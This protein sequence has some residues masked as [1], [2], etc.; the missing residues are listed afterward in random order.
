MTL[1]CSSDVCND[2]C[3]WLRLQENCGFSAVAVH[4]GRRFPVA[5]QRLIPMVLATIAFPQLRVD[6]VVDALLCRSCRFPCVVQRQFPM[7]QTFRRTTEFPMLLHKVIDVPVCR[8]CWSFTSP[9]MRRGGFPRSRLLSDQRDS[10][11]H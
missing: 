7:V 8:S 3:L 10:P 11:V 6:T 1:L 9:L 2:R 4:H 5:V